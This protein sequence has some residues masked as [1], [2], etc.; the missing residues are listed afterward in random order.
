MP[1]SSRRI[2]KSLP[3]SIR[4]PSRS[5]SRRSA[6]HIITQCAC[7]RDSSSAIDFP[8]AI[9]EP[10]LGILSP[11]Y[12]FNRPF[13]LFLS[14]LSPT[15]K[16]DGRS[17]GAITPRQRPGDPRNQRAP[18]AKANNKARARSAIA[19][20]ENVYNELA[21]S[22]AC[23]RDRDVTQ[24]LYLYPGSLCDAP[25]SFQSGARAPNAISQSVFRDP[26]DSSRLR[27][28]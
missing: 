4:F 3:I 9:S 27:R 24:L 18:C 7:A 5:L 15:W 19:E 2:N 6:L 26:L 17:R 11:F 16:P 21:R 14:S 20:R 1:Q 23:A 25:F 13:S 8:L 28:L 10:Y 12:L 22:C